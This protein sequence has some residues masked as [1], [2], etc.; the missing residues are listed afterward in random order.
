MI[1][2][3]AAIYVYLWLAGMAGGAYFTAF[4][5]DRFTGGGNKKLLRLA[6]YLGIPLAVIGVILLIVE[7]G[8]PIRFWHLLATFSA[9]SPMSM[10][11]W[12]LLVWVFAAVIMVVL[13]WAERFLSEGA[14]RGLQQITGL[15]SWIGVIFAVLLMSYTGVLLSVSSQPL[16]SGTVL[17]P[18]LFVASAV[19][20]GVAALIITALIA[21]A[22]TKGGWTELKLAINQITGSTDW[23]ISNHTVERLAETDV[24]VIVIELV[25]LI[26]YVIWLATST[27]VGVVE[28]LKLLTIGS[29]AAPFWI[30]VVLL[31]LLIPLGLE[32]INWGKQIENK[33]VWR[34]VVLS[35]VC[36]IV[37]GL[38]LRAVITIG[39]QI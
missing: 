7:L 22:I 4:L 15:L 5:F 35:S 20:T 14:T 6:T 12:I 26:G 36:V 39:G 2:W 8:Q 21:T 30:G 34:T 3:N 25:V 27:M 28:A 23:A 10:G 13:W 32:G 16:W 33:A 17:L 29:L 9:S 1:T 24:A 11:T 19:S 18:V 37:G 31:A 38:I